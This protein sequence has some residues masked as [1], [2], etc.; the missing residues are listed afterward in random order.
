MVAQCVVVS[1]QQWRAAGLSQYQVQIAVVIDIGIGGSSANHWPSEIARLGIRRDRVAPVA[2]FT[3]IPE[4]LGGLLVMLAGVNLVDLILK[5]PVRL[6]EVLA[7]IKIHIEEREAEGQSWSAG[8]TDAFHQGLVGE[9]QRI[10][11]CLLY[12]SPSPR[13]ATLSRMPSSA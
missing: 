10:D 9:D 2:A 3:L 5:V 13:D 12:T 1:K 8:G 6:N 7:A 4:E 11:G